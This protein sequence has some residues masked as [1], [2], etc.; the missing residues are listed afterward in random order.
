MTPLTYIRYFPLGLN[1]Y[2]ITSGYELQILALTATL[3]DG[4]RQSN[5][6]LA[7]I[8]CTDR[9]T[10]INAINRLRDKKLINNIGTRYRRILVANSEIVSLFNSEKVSQNS[11][12]VSPP[13]SE[14]LSQSG[15]KGDTHNN[16][17]VKIEN[18]EISF[19]LS[20]L[21]LSLILQRK[22]DFRDGQPERKQKTLERWARDAD[23]MI[24]RDDRTPECIER[25]IRWTQGDTFWKNNVL[26]MDTVR[27]RF[28]QLEM[29]M[30]GDN[31]DGVISGSSTGGTRK[32]IR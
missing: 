30:I 7:E 26:S 8:L 4:L 16:K 2:G 6:Q 9:R 21:L 22:A 29:K 13:N 25:V 31:G 3:P 24:R 20:N 5:N 1:Q 14:T 32:Y 23:L 18:K 28:D 27:R 11:E 17:K 10:I 19:Q 12:D 15:E